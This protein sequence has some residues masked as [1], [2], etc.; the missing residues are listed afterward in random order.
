M[1]NLAIGTILF[2]AIIVGL[3]L[4]YNPVI[5]KKTKPNILWYGPYWNRKY[6]KL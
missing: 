5:D 6:I 3:I 4:Y 1:I 2:A